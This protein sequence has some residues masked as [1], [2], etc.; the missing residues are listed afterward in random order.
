M[1]TRFYSGEI[2]ALGL[3]EQLARGL[4][5]LGTGQ[6]LS[7]TRSQFLEDHRWA[8]E[9]VVW[10]GPSSDEEEKRQ[11]HFVCFGVWLLLCWCLWLS[12]YLSSGSLRRIK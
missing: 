7:E 3:H 1:R 8:E 5:V 4:G 9:R 10:S 11:R 6:H 2:A 12:K